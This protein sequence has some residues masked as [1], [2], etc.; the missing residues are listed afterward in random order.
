M[1]GLLSK[2]RSL[3]E[4]G[5]FQTHV[6]AGFLIVSQ[7]KQSNTIV[8]VLLKGRLPGLHGKYHPQHS[9]KT[10][11]EQFIKEARSANLT[12]AYVPRI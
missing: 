8:F 4:C 11:P 6:I 2:L 1:F 9:H 5:H 3:A 12:S 10:I 7:Y